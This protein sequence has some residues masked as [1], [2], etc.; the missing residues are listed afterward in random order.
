MHNR[1]ARFC[2]SPSPSFPPTSNESGYSTD[3]ELESEPGSEIEFLE[4]GTLVPT[5]GPARKIKKNAPMTAEQQQARISELNDATPGLA[6]YAS[7]PGS[8]RLCARL[9]SGLLARLWPYGSVPLGHRLRVLGAHL[10]SSRTRLLLA[11]RSE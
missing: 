9:A 6:V 5:H 10:P 3:D 1:M 7:Q 8:P 11:H 2:P 4:D